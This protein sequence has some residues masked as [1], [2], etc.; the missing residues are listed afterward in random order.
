MARTVPTVHNYV[1]RMIRGRG[2]GKGQKEEETGHNTCTVTADSPENE[3]IVA[4]RE[5]SVAVF[6]DGN[7]PRKVRVFLELK[8]DPVH[9]SNLRGENR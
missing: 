5:E 3:S 7:L 1:K 8:V 6:R 2:E 4:G 9:E